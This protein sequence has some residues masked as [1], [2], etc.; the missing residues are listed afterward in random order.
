[1]AE[2]STTTAGAL[3][4]DFDP[5]DPAHLAD[6]H[7]VYARMRELEPMHWNERRGLWFATRYDDVAQVLRD[8]RHFS[9]AQYNITKPHMTSRPADGKRYQ[10]FKGATMVTT[11]PPE[12]T[13][14][15]RGSAAAFGPGGV[16]RLRERVR[17]IA[18]RLL[19][20]AA[21]RGGMDVIADYAYGLPVYAIAELLGVPEADQ[22]Q[23]MRFALADRGSPAHDPDADPEVLARTEAH[24]AELRT[25]V[26]AVVADKRRRPGEDLISALLAS[27]REDGLTEA[28]ILDTIHL[29]MEA[30][31]ITTVNLIGNGLDVLLDRP[32]DLRRLREDPELA[33]AV[34]RECLRFAGPVQFTGRTAISD[35]MLG[36]RMVRAGESVIPVLPAA[37]RDPRQFLDPDEF[38]IDRDPN[39][40]LA[41]GIGIHVCIGASLARLETE[42]AFATL[43]S[44]FPALRRAG[45]ARWNT[46]FELRGRTT[47][48]VEF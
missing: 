12:H 27:E 39:R 25:F 37:N 44:R 23:F 13:R 26:E 28:E 31:H 24:G 29:M 45:G 6:P 14:L 46:S 38:V 30:G 35:V 9:C 10:A 47:L 11:E 16:R 40:H 22:E 5:W 36:G 17:T 33:P 8:Q 1:M 7:A 3:G 34:V 42:I 4:A 2:T 32:E 43:V 20:H 41:F 48:P 15:R 18:D 19:D 21:A